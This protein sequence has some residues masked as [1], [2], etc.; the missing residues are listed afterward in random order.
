MIRVGQEY[1]IDR[2][3]LITYRGQKKKVMKSLR[4]R[5]MAKSQVVNCNAQLQIFEFVNFR[6]SHFKNVDFRKASFY[7]CDFWGA[8]FTKCRFN[9]AKFVSCVFMACKFKNCDFSETEF[10]CTTIVNTNLSDCC[11]I[12]VTSGLEIYHEYPICDIDQELTDALEKLKFNRNLK[13]NKLLF[14]SDKKYNNL[15]L[16][17]LQKQYRK[18]LPSL[19]TKLN[20]QSTANITTYKKLERT[21]HKIKKSD[22][23]NRSRPTQSRGCVANET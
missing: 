2:L 5:Y 13:K 7:G 16:F 20:D 17:L 18:H 22:I 6:G 21:L 10:E 14:I 4:C 8:S 19:L 9:G 3:N 12:D 15:N 1:R 11:N 23:I